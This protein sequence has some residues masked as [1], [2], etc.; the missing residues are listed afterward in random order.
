ML[1]FFFS[2]R[3]RHTR[4]QGD[5]S[6]DVCSSDLWRSRSP[7]HAA[8]SPADGAC[9]LRQA[10]ALTTARLVAESG[11]S[12]VWSTLV[13]RSGGID[14]SFI[15]P[16]V[17]ANAARKKCTETHE[18]ARAGPQRAAPAA[19]SARRPFRP[20]ADPSRRRSPAAAA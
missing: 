13:R 12:A 14:Q 15:Q 17:R 4:L 8:I 5:W 10:R 18:L 2:S 9:P 19:L 7:T 20:C 3:R 11:G 1:F 6:S 16:D